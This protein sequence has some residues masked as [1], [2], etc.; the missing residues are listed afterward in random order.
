MAFPGRECDIHLCWHPVRRQDFAGL[1]PLECASD[2]RKRA[3]SAHVPSLSLEGQE[4]W[5][6][7]AVL[8]EHTYQECGHWVPGKAIYLNPSS[9]DTTLFT[10]TGGGVLQQTGSSHFERCSNQKGQH[11]VMGN[12]AF[13]C[14]MRP[15]NGAARP[16][17]VLK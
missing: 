2:G 1:L 5:P 6:Q 11:D 12:C 14:R 8:G 16:G 9:S 13:L 17:K 10:G 4:V 15:G 7:F 3:G